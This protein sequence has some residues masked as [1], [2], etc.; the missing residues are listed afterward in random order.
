MRRLTSWNLWGT[1]KFTRDQRM[2]ARRRN[3]RSYQVEQ[4]E[5]RVLLSAT[6]LLSNE[7]GPAPA[8]TYT[9]FIVGG[10]DNFLDNYTASAGAGASLTSIGNNLFTVT[11]PDAVNL[12]A[13]QNMFANN[14][15]V[16]YV[17]P[18]FELS[19]ALSPNDPRYTNG[20]L[21]GLHNTGG[22]GRVADADIDAPE[23]WDST[24]GDTRFG[25]GVIDT[26][27]DY[28]HPDLY[29]NIWL[30]QDEIPSSKSGATDIDSDGLITF[31]D[32]N[33]ASNSSYTSDLNGN[34]YIDG[35]DLLSD[36]TWEN[37][38][39]EDNNGYV[40][41]LV[42]WDFANGD[43]DPYD[44][45]GHGTHC[46][47][48]I[49][50]I[51]NNGTGVVGV[52]WV[53][54]VAGLKF[55]GGGGT[56]STA[57]AVSAVNYAA[58]IRA[59]G[60]NLVMTS[61]SW[62]G[63]GSSNSMINAI[64][65]ARDEGQM[66]FAAAGNGN[67]N[68]DLSPSY[69]ASYTHDNIIA[70][71]ANGDSDERAS[72]TQWGATSVDITAPGVGIWS[73]TP[74]GQ[75]ASFNGTSM[76]TPHVAGAAALLYSHKPTATW[77]EVR[78]AI[79]NSVDTQSTHPNLSWTTSSHPVKYGGRLNVKQAMDELGP[80]GP[81]PGSVE[82]DATTYATTATANVRVTDADRNTNDGAV[83]TVTVSVKSTTEP[84]GLTVTLTETG[85]ASGIFTADV[86]IQPG[87]GPV[88]DS[89]LQVADGDT[90]T[91]TYVD[92][93]PVGTHNDTATIDGAAPV[94]T[95][96]STS[97]GSTSAGVSWDTN[98]AATGVVD[99]GLSPGSLNSSVSASTL[100]TSQSVTLPGLT[101][102]TTYFYRVTATD[103]VGNA[104]VDSVRSF[105]TAAQPDLLFVDDDEGDPWE[106]YFTDALDVHSLSYDVWTVAAD[107]APS[108]ADLSDYS[109]VL[110]NCGHNYTASTAGL[111]SAEQT[112]ISQY[113]DGGGNIGL[114]TQDSL[115]NG[116]DTSFYQTY[117]GLGSYV[118][119]QQGNDVIGVPGDPIGDG[120]N[121]NLSFP[122][123]YP[124]WGDS[125]TPLSSAEGVFARSS[126]MV[127]YNAIRYDSGDFRSVF[128]AFA[129]EALPTS[130]TAPNNQ[131]T[132]LSRVVEWLGE[133]AAPPVPTVSIGDAT[134]TEGGSASLTLTLSATSSDDV[135]V[136]Y[137]TSNASA[138]AGDDYTGV[139]S[140]SAVI[141]AGNISTTISISTIEDALD[142]SNETF[143]VNLSGATNATVADGT[144]IVTIT[145][146]DPSPSIS[147]SDVTQNEGNSGTTN[148]TFTVTLDAASGRAVSVN[149]NTVDGSATIGD[150]DYNAANGTINFAAGDTS[151]QFTVTGNGDTKY[152]ANETFSVNLS[153]ASNATIGDATG[154]GTLTND[155]NPPTIS[156]NDVT[157]AEGNSG[158]TAFTFTVSLS[159][160]SGLPASVNYN[161][162][163]G[164]AD[165]GSDYT[166]ASGT[167]NFAAGTTSQQITVDVNGDTTVEGDETF[168]VNL[169]S[170]VQATI[171]DGQGL[172]T[173][174]EDD[175]RLSISNVTVDEDAGNATFTVSLTGASSQTVSVN[176]GTANGSAIAG[177]DYTATS[178][179]LNFTPGQTSK[180]IDVPITDDSLDENTETFTVNLS[181]PVNAGIDDGSGLGT[182]TDNDAAP[183]I[184]INNVTIAEGDSGS[185]TA[186]LT[187]TLSAASG[188]DISVDYDTADGSA[189]GGSDYTAANGTLNFAPGQTTKTVNVSVLG[190]TTDENI[191]TFDVNLSAA[192]NA[193]IAD[194]TGQV[195][196]ID[197]DNATI[198]IDDVTG[199][200]GDSGTTDFTFTVSL[201]VASAQTVTVDY[202]T[203]DGT[204]VDSSDYGSTGG[205][206]TFSPGETSQTVTVAVN[207]D[208]NEEANE[209]FTVNLSNA[210]NAA[211]VD[212]DGTGTIVN[213]DDPTPPP[214]SFQIA[215]GVVEN[216]DS[217]W[218]TL[219]FSTTMNN[220]VIVTTVSLGFS[221]PSSNPV[222]TQMRNVTNTS[223]DLRVVTLDGM[224]SFASPV[225][226][227]VVAVNA[228]EYSADGLNMEA[229]HVDVSVTDRKGSWNGQEVAYQG[230]YSNPVVLG[231]VM[232][233]NDG[234][235]DPRPSTFWSR[236]L[237][238]RRNIPDSSGMRIGK[239]LGEDPDSSRP[240]ETVGYIVLES[241]LQS[242]G[243]LQLSAQVTADR[244]RGV[245]NN[246]PHFV[247]TPGD[248]DTV[249]GTVASGC[250]MDGADGYAAV[251]FEE[252]TT[253]GV[254]LA[255]SEDLYKDFEQRHTTE[256]S[257][258]LFVGT[259]ST[260]SSAA[261]AAFARSTSINRFGTRPARSDAGAPDTPLA[262]LFS[263]SVGAS[264]DAAAAPA[265]N[266]PLFAPPA[267]MPTDPQSTPGFT[268]GGAQD[269]WWSDLGNWGSMCDD[270]VATPPAGA[271]AENPLE[272]LLTGG[273]SNLWGNFV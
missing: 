55:L 253:A 105:T 162:A 22:T 123:G 79:F 193:T 3:H 120:V 266:L 102:S 16:D 88:A 115:Y 124:N 14:P 269:S 214:T 196:I 188:K 172:G 80:T 230:T 125:L 211:I 158:T 25:V 45:N 141:S 151:K 238:S 117:L 114:F 233:A 23:A 216:V 8:P 166:T 134:V 154:V 127:D 137:A 17:E 163:N 101:A 157:Q 136:T 251:F 159:Q 186:T 171:L 81:G 252:P 272:T 241:G 206:L 228:G 156:I 205:Q 41:D 189:N 91:A 66:F 168:T 48:T 87:S 243:D 153:G 130:G 27:I 142:E 33:H 52:N 26:G 56:G 39:D 200:E 155:D 58:A 177:S 18:N 129:F 29:L 229:G 270:L 239:H 60:G 204:A 28:T 30:N 19:V 182:I 76:A 133:A 36:A 259:N 178:G 1:G 203:V 62:G 183:E 195:T 15:F 7:M 215:T 4:L 250:G 187:V 59:N 260:A 95:N 140:G 53:G 144:G 219:E 242:L 232:T 71:A 271:A 222:W 148:Y 207:G 213:D 161:T 113:L 99:Y 37:G 218:K 139:S 54:Q 223:F 57:D 83:E 12:T 10:Q 84:G 191:E 227:Y 209:T 38:T 236:S 13:M 121:T 20:D 261:G 67:Y 179:T 265:A 50:G 245:E 264:T 152:E 180:T 226:V 63:G 51:G 126:S 224:G 254:E 208:T 70:V 89:I 6:G 273:L 9:E 202:Q 135:T 225:N 107:G 85:V 192:S 263:T 61:N 198:T 31:Y 24:T 132:V 164:S 46:A 112:V 258:I 72:F 147:I 149:Y 247:S 184:S 21:Y 173:I 109:V 165:A 77:T 244:V 267:D 35:G 69:P 246:R 110:Y 201:S 97:P 235:S 86:S 5:D 169:N 96:V 78:D 220:P 73:T 240:T 40:D 249:W 199:A 64:N 122:T 32:L 100:Q 44:D 111:T 11:V 131:A 98:E 116:L 255:A 234:G 212:G 268:A 74:N 174:E 150:G 145:D 47:G 143:N 221:G 118:N 185:Q 34:G 92:P 257:S 181:S 237:T 217:N 43:N 170:P 108:A 194:P 248:M 68:N 106:D 119:D 175:Q 49:A 90:I 82:F 65:A 75:Y 104:S 176:Y 256:N 146:D 93:D 190:D 42:G 210:A 138:V 167:I 197:D 231:Q 262:G 94:I 128:F 160:A 103:A 2:L